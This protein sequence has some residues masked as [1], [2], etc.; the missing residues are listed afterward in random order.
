MS[1]QSLAVQTPPSSHADRPDLHDLLTINPTVPDI[2]YSIG[3]EL[4]L[5]VNV[6][7]GIKTKHG[8]PQHCKRAMFKEWLNTCPSETC[9]WSHLIQALRK[10]DP[11][12]ADVIAETIASSPKETSLKSDQPHTS[13]FP[14][15]KSERKEVDTSSISTASLPPSL[16]SGR[17]ERPWTD[18]VHD[19]PTS[20]PLHEVAITGQQLSTDVLK[21]T[22]RIQDDYPP[23]MSY[24]D[25]SHESRSQSNRGSSE[26]RSFSAEE[27]Q[28]ASEDDS[29][30]PFVINYQQD[31]EQS[32]TFG[33]SN[34]PV[35]AISA[36]MLS[37]VFILS[38]FA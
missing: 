27:Y 11:R 18:I 26:T 15:Q 13:R 25:K 14:L 33:A 24:D 1:K 6:L 35:S 30:Q 12:T 16:I 2:W 4:G 29:I 31:V 23:L 9:T 22:G 7:N 20:L 28:T 3:L 19:P 21:T 17:R 38:Y 8:K 36:S 32:I 34:D 10:V 37:M 5:S